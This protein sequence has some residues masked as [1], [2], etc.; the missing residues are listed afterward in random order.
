MATAQPASKHD[1]EDSA[2]APTTGK[3]GTAPSSGPSGDQKKKRG[4]KNKGSPPNASPSNPTVGKANSQAVGFTEGTQALLTYNL[5]LSGRK[6]R[7]LS[8]FK[9]DKFFHLVETAW[10]SL[11][12]AK[13]YIVERFSY[14]EFRH[15]S[16]L[17]LYQRMEQVKFDSLGVKPSAPTRIPLPRNTRVFQPIWSVLANIG[18]VDD[19][20][21]R[22]TYIPDGILPKS[23]DLSDPDDIEGLLACTLYL[24]HSRT[25][26]VPLSTANRI[27]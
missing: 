25:T 12:D 6:E 17:M 19:D 27:V 20:D 10:S 21:L 23:S 3:S 1:V 11:V 14:P 5:G 2:S 24:P 22:V 4:G 15:V 26:N 9:A 16:A 7:I 13:P 18:R 8:P